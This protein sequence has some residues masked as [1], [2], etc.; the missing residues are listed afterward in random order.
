MEVNSQPHAPAALSPGKD[1]M[2]PIELEAGWASGPVWTFWEFETL[3][4]AVGSLVAIPTVLSWFH[5]LC[6]NATNI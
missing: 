4:R 3:D 2:V 6:S 1:H 5:T